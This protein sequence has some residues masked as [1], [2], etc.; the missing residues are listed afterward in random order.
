MKSVYKLKLES[1]KWFATTVFTESHKITL[2]RNI[3]CLLKDRDQSGRRVYI[4]KLGNN[5]YLIYFLQ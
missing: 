5:D 1:P 2:L 3:H 4:I